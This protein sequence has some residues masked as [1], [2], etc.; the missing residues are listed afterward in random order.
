MPSIPEQENQRLF[1]IWEHYDIMNKTFP[2]LFLTNA[3]KLLNFTQII[4]LEKV[5]PSIEQN[6]IDIYQSGA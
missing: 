2:H 4:A 5:C 6:K 1:L 3:W